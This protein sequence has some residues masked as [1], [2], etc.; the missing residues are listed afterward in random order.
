MSKKGYFFIMDAIIGLMVMAIAIT[1][2]FSTHVYQQPKTQI[3]ELTDSLMSLLSENKLIALNNRYKD[4]LIMNGNI[5]NI[6]NS[7]LEQ[8]NEF[9]YRNKTKG[10]GFCM[11][12]SRE[13]VKNLTDGL[14]GEQYN[15]RFS[16]NNQTIYEKSK[17]GESSS[18]LTLKR[19][20][21]VFTMINDNET[22]GP[23]Y[24]EMSIWQ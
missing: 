9:D 21:I 18:I 12:L 1:Y 13:L 23:K 11:N 17:Y 15:F 14:I 2:L 16:L 4:T 20:K 8:V 6:Y 3:Y 5:T 22:Y 19:S 24:A 7:V 10:C